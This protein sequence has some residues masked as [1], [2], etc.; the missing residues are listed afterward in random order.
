M[1]CPVSVDRDSDAG[2][3]CSC[4]TRGGVL[5]PMTGTTFAHSRVVRKLSGGGMS[6]FAR[7]ETPICASFASELIQDIFGT[8]GKQVSRLLLRSK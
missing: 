7:G 1:R 3:P 8:S 6:I 2:I 5:S 4:F